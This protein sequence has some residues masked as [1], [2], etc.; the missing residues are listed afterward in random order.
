MVATSQELPQEAVYSPSPFHA[1][2]QKIQTLTGAR[3][4]SEK[5]GRSWHSST[6]QPGAIQFLAEQQLLYTSSRNKD[7]Q[8]WASVVA[9]PRG[10]LTSP[11]PSKLVAHP[12][13]RLPG[14]PAELNVGEHVGSLGIT[15]Q[16]RRRERVNGIVTHS[17]SDSLTLSVQQSFSGCPKYI[18]ARVVEIDEE[19]LERGAE[20]KACS[21]T[22]GNAKLGDAEQKFIKSA[23]T[24]FLATC[25]FG[26]LEAGDGVVGCDTSHRGG[27]LGFVQVEKPGTLQFA[28]YVGNF[29]FT[30]LGNLMDDPRASILFLD[31]TTGSSLQLSGRCSIL[32][33]E[34]Q[35][36]GAQRT[37][38]FVTQKW[39]HIRNALP[40]KT[41]GPVKWSPYNPLPTSQ[42]CEAAG[43]D[44]IEQLF[45]NYVDQGSA[46]QMLRCLTVK[47]EALDVMTFAFESYKGRGSESVL[48]TPGQFAS[49]DF[50]GIKGKDGETLNRTWTISSPAQEMKAKEQFSVTIKKVG[51]VSGWMFEN[52]VPGR[53]ICFRGVDGDFTLDDR[54]K[55]VPPAGVLLIGGGIGITPIRVL[56]HDCVSRGIPVTLLYCTRTL[57]DAV[58]LE[59]LQKVAEEGETAKV[60]ITLTNDN[61][62][63][64]RKNDNGSCQFLQGRISAAML[65][66]VCGD[67]KERAIFQCGPASMMNAVKAELKILGFP[68]LNLHQEDFSF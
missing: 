46:V 7:G 10:F 13:T 25:W 43:K 3:E 28:D 19:R 2:E 9:G 37:M 40:F 23:D 32:W 22:S 53:V 55:S 4:V 65:E 58:F 62:A 44:R 26:N 51:L 30:T 41:P 15:L 17:H 66:Q 6:L 67:V 14:D 20:S 59:D 64:G 34:K 5:L 61:Q 11:A 49:F 56:L 42:Y 16:T 31:W 8:L 63:H 45:N 38:K 50:T 57:A 52:M 60:T 1:G 12:M 68:F 35:L 54:M 36:P 33:D 21:C 27:P 48:A 39:V 47:R 24:L 18:Q 29:T